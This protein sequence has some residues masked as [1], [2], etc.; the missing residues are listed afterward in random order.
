MPERPLTQTE[1]LGGTL[2]L[3][4]ERHFLVRPIRVM[5]RM[6]RRNRWILRTV[7]AIPFLAV[8]AGIILTRSAVTRWIVVPQLESALNMKLEAGA[9][10]VGFDGRLYIDRAKFR[11]PGMVGPAGD[12]LRVSRVE[13]NVDWLGSLGGDPKLRGIAMTE[14]V[15][16][17]SQ[18]LSDGSLNIGNLD[19]PASSGSTAL[20]NITVTNAGIQLA[21]HTD[22]TYAVLKHVRMDGW[23]VPAKNDPNGYTFQLTEKP[24]R[25]K[26]AGETSDPGFKLRGNLGSNG[27]LTVTVENFSLTDW[28][29][30]SIPTHVRN[31]FHELH[32]EGEVPRAFLTYTE[33]KGVAA[34]LELSG[35]GM[36]LPIQ[37]T[38]V[39]TIPEEGE[40]VI[41]L[42]GPPPRAMRMHGV[43][44]A[45]TFARDQVLADVSGSVENL[46]YHVKLIYQGTDA[47][48]PFECTVTSNDFQVTRNPRLLL[49]APPV[50]KYRLATFS[51]PTAIVNTRLTIRRGAPVNGEP[52]PISLGGE[53]DMRDGV[54][55]YDDFPYEFQ[56]LTG[57]FKFTEDSLE[58]ENVTGRSASGAELTAHGRISPLTD[59][60]QVDVAVDVRNA[61]IDDTM[62]ASFG[63]DRGAML[64]A[65][66]NK[67]RYEELIKLGLVQAPQALD[68]VKAEL[69]ALR[70]APEPRAP[71]AAARLGELERLAQVPAF[72]F[73][74]SADVSVRVHRPA[75]KDTDWQ[76]DVE[77]KL[78]EAGL[79][80]EKFPL[81]IV[82]RNVVARV[83]DRTGALVAGEFRGLTGGDADVT[84]S[85]NVPFEDDA[86]QDIRPDI[87]IESRGLPLDRLLIH[88]L[89]G[90]RATESGSGSKVKQILT[91]L[92]ATGTGEGRVR[93]A[94]RTP[95]ELGF[96][97]DFSLSGAEMQPK[98][99]E[100]GVG[101]VFGRVRA[102]ESKVEIELGAQARERAGDSWRI[103]SG[104]VQMRINADI[105][106][107]TSNEQTSYSA[108]LSIPSI[109]IASKVEPL[110]KIFSEAAADKIAK[111]RAEHRPSGEIDLNVAV[112]SAN[113]DTTVRLEGKGAKP[114]S[115]DAIQGRFTLFPSSGG[116]KLESGDETW[117]SFDKLHGRMLF[118]GGEAGWVE[119][120]GSLLVSPGAT[121][122][123]STGA[124]EVALR[125]APVES[126][127]AANIVTSRLNQAELWTAHQPRGL[128]EAELLFFRGAGD[129][130]QVRGSVAPKTLT[131]HSAGSDLTFTAV[132]GSIDFGPGI[133]ALRQLSVQTPDWT[134][135][136]SGSWQTEG[137][138]LSAAVELDLQGER[139][140]EQLIGLLPVEVATIARDLK[141]RLNGPFQLQGATL[142]MARGGRPSTR[143]VGTLE[144]EDAA[145][146]A[147]LEVERLAGSTSINYQRTGESPATFEVLT[148][149]PRL[150]AAGIAMSG[151]HVRVTNGDVA[152]E[153]LV[154]EASAHVHGGRATAVARI[155]PTSAEPGS[156]AYTASV[157][158]SGLRFASLLKDLESK[159]PV[160]GLDTSDD[161]SRG[162]LEGNFTL[163]GTVGEP[164][165]RRGRGSFQ[166]AGGRILNIPFAMRMVELSNLQLPTNARLGYAKGSF[167]IAGDLVTFEELGIF[168]SAVQILGSGTMNWPDKALD[169]RFNTKPARGIPILSGLI[170]GIRDEL[171][172][173]SVRGTISK[174]D[175][176]LR[177]FP[178]PR[179][180]LDHAVG[181]DQVEAPA[182]TSGRN[183][184]EGRPVAEGIRPRQQERP[185]R[186][187]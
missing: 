43:T 130:I 131:V 115:F 13:V 85:F 34:R 78:P 147:G 22:A 95:G 120:G 46:P 160:E 83:H 185:G 26:R 175:I 144:T 179:R 70:R 141:V 42:Y 82:A 35:V 176:S 61:P 38:E 51:S 94:N 40:P 81:P 170:G 119:V 104:P 107:S 21:E 47:N 5:R 140:T 93:I 2:E 177:Q 77:I 72:A 186:L 111:L 125:D 59:D 39:T 169:L 17:I 149:A 121:A 64:R 87:G 138:T 101:N 136:A 16:V 150:Q 45:I 154:H 50:V 27:A 52:G 133:G 75:G 63:E 148:N 161:R 187:N 65:L 164:K 100:V 184:A 153:V 6:K 156:K 3:W 19:L 44:G 69:D 145:I 41:D 97:A 103:V 126:P 60:A 124:V 12:F 88:A 74:G 163:Q 11:L 146:E 53:L 37:P 58:F 139:G 68:A 129:E 76:T 165:T 162:V 183:T 178:G 48:A 166:I 113:D 102:S 89:P 36:D 173:T 24:A 86:D 9:V 135:A 99:S 128:Y 118:D 62:E 56:N 110:V 134:A 159:I 151:G 182:A 25:L 181:A 98:D 10:Y 7:L 15:V 79:L 84:A 158:L 123:R 71:E 167:F 73:R 106:P 67:D 180:I 30:T 28:P 112:A 55:A 1:P 18:S 114:V 152:G 143:F 157:N 20:P 108:L 54:A 29:D 137:D 132:H 122:R 142:N 57:R 109:D 32:L 14:P 96:D 66:F 49:Y 116:F 23:L 172:T 127:L 171:V 31:L 8:T 174:P 155:V 105:P 4:S 80:P 33:D 92:N 91:D 90:G 168:S 117:I